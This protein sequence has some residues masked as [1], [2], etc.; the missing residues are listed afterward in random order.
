MTRTLRTREALA[1]YLFVAPALFGFLVFIAGPILVSA[2]FSLTEYKLTR[3]PQWAGLQNYQTLWQDELF[4]QSLNVTV[5]YAVLALPLG[6][7]LSLGLALLLNQKLWGVAFWRT[8]YYL[9]AVIS[10]VAVAVLWS[11]ILNPEFG[12]LNTFLRYLGIQGPNWLGD[13]R[14]ALPALVLISLWG[15]GGNMLTYLAG[16]QGIPTELYEAASIDG[17]GSWRRLINITLPLL[18]PVIFF[19]LVMGLIG[20]FQFFTEPFIMTRGGPEQSTLSYMLYLYR[21]AFT[22]FKMG[23]AAALAWVL[24]LLV[25]LLTLAV[26]RSSP[27]WVHYEAQRER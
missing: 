17:A 19:N 27:I 12:L 8:V 2:Y 4:W 22:Y 9:P 18:S 13:T 26:F 5:R 3:S 7:V 6:L 14:T 15:I 24:F 11:W 16:L 20:V 21:N 25:L 1:G 10:G 23:Y